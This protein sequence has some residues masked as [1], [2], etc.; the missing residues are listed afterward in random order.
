[1]SVCG[2][3]PVCCRNLL[4]LSGKVPRIFEMFKRV[5]PSR[6][7][8]FLLLPYIIFCLSFSYLVC[9]FNMMYSFFFFSVRGDNPTSVFS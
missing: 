5:F 7:S 6:Q 2:D 9:L 8:I 3:D 1:M 4:V